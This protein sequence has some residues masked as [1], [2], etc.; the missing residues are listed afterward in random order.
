[1]ETKICWGKCKDN[2]FIYNALRIL[3][4]Y[5]YST[6]ECF[7]TIH[8][9]FYYLFSN[10]SEYKRNELAKQWMDTLILSKGDKITRG[11]PDSVYSKYIYEW[12]HSIDKKDVVGYPNTMIDTKIQ[13]MV[14][15]IKP[16]LSNKHKDALMIDIGSMDCQ[17][18]RDLSFLLGMVPISVSIPYGHRT[19]KDQTDIC[20][21]IDLIKYEKKFAKMIRSK[22]SAKV[23]VIIFNHSLHHFESQEEIENALQQAYLLLEK[24]GILLIRDH[25]SSNDVFINLQHIVLEM[26]YSKD[27][28]LLDFQKHMHDYTLAFQSHYLN[29][30]LIKQLCKNI[31]FSYKTFLK[32]Q[33]NIKDVCNKEIDISS[34]MYL[35]FKKQSKTRRVL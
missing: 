23:Q 33:T 26:K 25:D 18:A 22:Y 17:I 3:C 24:G 31:G 1:M 15:L 20:K 8:N 29:Q 4:N 14:Q 10:I 35:C 19:R 28:E 13:D 16:N 11:V 9:L 7:K 32:K 34:T 12:Y 6:I 27:M 30:K 5:S 21:N 2:Y